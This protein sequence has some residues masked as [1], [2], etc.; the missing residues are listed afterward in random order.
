MSMSK[1]K[2]KYFKVFS[3]KKQPNKKKSKEKKRRKDV[4][5]F[6]HYF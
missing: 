1:I 4:H 3:I 6:L 2:K 5:V